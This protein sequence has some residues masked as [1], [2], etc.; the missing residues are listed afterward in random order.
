MKIAPFVFVGL[1]FGCATAVVHDDSPKHSTAVE[2]TYVHNLGFKGFFASESSHTTWTRSNMRRSEDEFQFSGFFMKH[3]AKTHDDAMIWRIDR[4]LLWRLDLDEKVYTE[5]PLTGCVGRQRPVERPREQTQQ[6]Q[7]RPERKPSCALTLAKHRFT[8]TPTGERKTINGFETKRYQVV[9]Q[10]V[11]Q[12]ARK[13]KD[14]STVNVDLWTASDSDPRLVAVRG[15]DAQFER[16]LHAASPRKEMDQVVPPEAMKVIALQFLSGLSASQRAA[17]TNVGQELS[18]IHGHAISTKLEWYLDG[19]ACADEQAQA[20]SADSGQKP[21]SL[22]FS[23]GVSGL[24]G[25]A[26]S[27]AAQKGVEKKAEEIQGRPVFGFEIEVKQIEL[28]PASD[29]LFVPPADFKK[30]A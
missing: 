27:M 8:V 26:G 21:S 2:R 29:G 9:W 28:A 11:V 14:T 23:H 3:M 17:I 13:R 5:C 10:V 19:D 16:A 18:K 12:D 25:S 30:K 20:R 7:P 22:D 24:F 4:R 15:V 6:Q 1:F